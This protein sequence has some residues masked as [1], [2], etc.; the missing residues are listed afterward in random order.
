MLKGLWEGLH[1]WSIM[2]SW[3]SRKRETASTTQIN[4]NFK[5]LT[6]DVFCPLYYYL[7]QT[8][9][10]PFIAHMFWTKAH[11]IGEGSVL[12]QNRAIVISGSSSGVQDHPDAGSENTKGFVL[13]V[14]EESGREICALY[15]SC[16]L[17]VVIA[18]IHS[19]FP[20]PGPC[21]VCEWAEL[22]LD[23]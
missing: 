4:F 17:S 5:H 22:E 18:T 12:I 1:L 15:C 19:H 7:S 13:I 20:P 11:L 6:F 10:F 14:S 16:S 21:L 8:D 2:S 23:R 3:W 9:R